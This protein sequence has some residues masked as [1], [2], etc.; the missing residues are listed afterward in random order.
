MMSWGDFHADLSTEGPFLPLKMG[1][2]FPL[3]KSLIIVLY[4]KI[5]N[6]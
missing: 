4:R 2:P 3:K 1:K 5:R 6:R